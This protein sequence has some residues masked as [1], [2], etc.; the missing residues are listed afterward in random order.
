MNKI[1][2]LN[3]LIAVSLYFGLRDQAKKYIDKLDEIDPY[4]DE[5]N[6][7]NHRI[8]QCSSERCR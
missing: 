5:G 7:T 1:Q 6:A 2:E 8:S 4:H 3:M